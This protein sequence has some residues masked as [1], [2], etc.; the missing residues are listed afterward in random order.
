MTDG[1]FVN[2]SVILGGG[3]FSYFGYGYA[4]DCGLPP[5]AGRISGNTVYSNS[6]IM[7]PCNNATVKACSLS[8]PLQTW[9]AEGHDVGTTLLPIPPDEEVIAAAKKLL[10]M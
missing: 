5:A 2:N 8:C 6:P 9:V 1:W 4:S 7:V 3:T 10:G